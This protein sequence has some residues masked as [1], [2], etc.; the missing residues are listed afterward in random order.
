VNGESLHAGDRIPAGDMLVYDAGK[1]EN[2][3]ARE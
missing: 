2:E 3:K 1:P